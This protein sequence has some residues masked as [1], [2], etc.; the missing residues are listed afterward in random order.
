MAVSNDTH[1][2]R[3]RRR[4]E[5]PPPAVITV[6]YA[7]P[8]TGAPKMAECLKRAWDILLKDPLPCEV[9]EEVRDAA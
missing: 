4:A 8:G 6:S 9:A 2:P 1:K 3:S 5:P 7:E